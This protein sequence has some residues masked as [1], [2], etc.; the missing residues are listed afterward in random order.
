MDTK[1][2]TILLWDNLENFNLPNTK[3]QYGSGSLY[4]NVI[5]FNSDDEFK[6]IF[7]KIDPSNLL[8]FCCHIEFEN[9]NGYLDFRNSQIKQN[10]NIP[11][12]IYLS[13]GDSIEAVTKL[14]KEN[15]PTK[16]IKYSGLLN[17]IKLGEIKPFKKQNLLQQNVTTESFTKVP[18]E[19]YPQIDYAIITALYKDEFEEVKKLFNF[20]EKDIIDTGIIEY[21]VGTLKNNNFKKI[22]AAIPN[23]TGM[24]D[25]AIV[26]TQMLEFF[27][28]KY[29]L[30]AGVCGGTSDMNFGDVVVGSQIY[31]FQKG[32]VSDLKGKNDN[33]IELYDRESK[34]IDYDHLY[35]EDGKHIN[36]SIEKF[37][38]EH[39][40]VISLDPNINSKIIRKQKDIQDLINEELK[41]FN[42]A[43]KIDLKPIACSTMVINKNG[44]F[45]DNIRS[46]NRKTAA[47][48]MESYGVARACTFAN[49]GKT[50]SII[51][52][53]VMDNMKNKGDEEKRFAAHTIATR[54]K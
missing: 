7:D 3:K 46:I 44:Y 43:I 8:V 51:F 35:D 50:K 20:D 36:I 9:L 53:S 10:F 4:K 27:R 33:K 40:S 30:M 17:G 49:N 39:D 15:E 25:S 12:V 52:K 21:H 41:P 5:Q 38:I 31:T 22:V 11:E 45:E 24:V 34:I 13:S 29:L 47:V 42:R 18:S 28:P 2:I 6:E 23:A 32:K 16:V 54:M 48:E 1:Q 14:Y 26:A 37:E 19:G